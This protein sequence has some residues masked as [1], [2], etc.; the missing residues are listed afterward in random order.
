MTE[1]N[2]VYIA[3]KAWWERRLDAIFVYTVATCILI[4]LCLL[5]YAHMNDIIAAG[6]NC[7]APGPHKHLKHSVDKQP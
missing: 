2:P 5:T 4:V 7:P 1:I 3:E 6:Q